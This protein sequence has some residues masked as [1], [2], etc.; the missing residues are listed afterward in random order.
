MAELAS[1]RGNQRSAFQRIIATI[2]TPSAQR[3]PNAFLIKGAA[4]TGKT[5]LLN[6]IIHHCQNED[7]K[8]IAISYTGIASCFLHKGRTVHSQFRIPWN[9][10]QIRCAI[11]NNS[12]IYKHV[13]QA[14]VL[15]W[16]QAAFCSRLIIEEVNRF[17]QVMMNSNQLFGGKVVVM[18]ADFRECAPIVKSTPQQ[19]IDSYSIL[20]SPLFDQ[21]QHF[22]LQDNLRFTSQAD[23]NWCLEIGS[24]MRQEVN[25]PIECRVYNLDTLINT[26][27]DRDFGSFAADDVVERS[28]ISVSNDGADFLNK[29]CLNRL[30]RTKF[31]CASINYFKKIDNERSS[32]FY[33]ME[34]V[35]MNLPKYFPPEIL[36]VS[37]NC[38]V[39]LQQSYRGLAPGTRLIVKNVAENRIVAEIAVGLRKGR[40]INIYRTLTKQIF[41][42]GNVEFIRRQFPLSLAFALTINKAQG[43]ELKR[44][45]VYFDTKVFSHGQMYVAFSRVPEIKQNIKVLI[46]QMGDSQLSY[47]RMLNVTNPNIVNGAVD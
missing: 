45:G 7:I 9:R 32:R 27:Y 36:L 24:G 2:S 28:I 26:V 37:E 20:F 31:M 23:Y 18:C 17:L 11:D 47:D 3:H 6:R 35:M 22:T 30:F 19:P 34:N 38:P 29:E 4:G 40:L 21:M 1:L 14:S 25:I 46:N 10:P 13:K 16:D 41:A 8:A 44:M 42:S 43:L 5:Y 33:V 39:M 15:L 12:P